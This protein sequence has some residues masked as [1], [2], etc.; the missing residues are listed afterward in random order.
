[1][2]TGYKWELYNVKEDPTQSNDLA[3][4]MPDKLK[5]MQA[6]FY[7]EAKKYDVLPLDN[8]TLAR[9]N[10]PRPSL[11][12]GRTDFTYSGELTGV[13]A[14]AAPSILNKSY[15]ITAEV[16]IPEGGAE[17]MIVTE[18]GRFGGYG[19][20][21]SKGD[22]GHSAAAS[23]C[24]STTCSTS[25]ARSGKG[26]SWSAGKHTIV[27]DFKSDGPGL[28]KGGT[29]V[30]SVDGK[31]VARNSMEHATPVTFPED[32]TFDVGQDTRTGVAMIEYRYDPPFK[33]T[34]K[35]NKLT[36]KLEPEVKDPAQA[37]AELGPTPA[38]D[39]DPIEEPKAKRTGTNAGKR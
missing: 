32:E 2:I 25:S 4:K 30:L 38:P 6:L 9:W 1:M 21:L 27:F 22:R 19:L 15:T 7:S 35:I 31:E 28:G 20:F 12:A 23:P 14:S 3:A 10:T 37:K 17:G 29:G 34:G 13:P 11:T 33:F 36:F 8:S 24:S 39:P 5:E 18:G 16:E 26:R